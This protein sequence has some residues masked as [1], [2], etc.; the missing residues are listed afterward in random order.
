LRA[1]FLESEQGTSIALVDL[2]IRQNS[3]QKAFEWANLSTTFDLVDYERLAG[4]EGQVKNP[5]ANQAY[6]EWKA[7]A[8]QLEALRQELQTNFSDTLSQQVRQQEAALSEQAE[9][10]VEKYPELADLLEITP[11][12]LAQLQANLPANK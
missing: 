11:T 6:Q 12:D 4:T 1:T 3:P 9:I 5:V 8:R 2:L 10:L 7:Q